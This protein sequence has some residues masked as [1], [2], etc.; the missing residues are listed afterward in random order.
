[1][2][3][4]LIRISA[5]L[6]ASVLALGSFSIWAVNT[7]EFADIGVGKIHEVEIDSNDDLKN[8]LVPVNEYTGNIEENK[9]L[10]SIDSEENFP[11]EYL[12]GTIHIHNA[13]EVSEHLKNLV[14][15]LKIGEN[16]IGSLSLSEGKIDF[17][18]DDLLEENELLINTTGQGSFTRRDTKEI[19][20]IDFLIEIEGFQERVSSEEDLTEPEEEYFEVEITDP[21]EFEQY[22]VNETVTMNYTVENTG[23]TE[24]AQ[25]IELLVD[26]DVKEIE[27]EIN[28]SIGEK[29][30]GQF[31][32]TAE[33]PYGERELQVNSENDQ[34]S[35]KIIV[36]GTQMNINDDE[37]TYV[38]EPN[39]WETHWEIEDVNV[40]GLDDMQLIYHY[41][42]EGEDGIF[43][44]AEAGVRILV[45]GEQVMAERTLGS[46]SE[47]WEDSA[48]V[49]GKD[50]V[51]IQFQYLTEYYEFILLVESEVT[52]SK[53]GYEYVLG[54][55]G[56][57][58]YPSEEISK[59]NLEG[60]IEYLQYD[61]YTS[62]AYEEWY[63]VIDATDQGTELQI[64]LEEPNSELE[65]V[66]VID[67]LVRRTDNS[68]DRIPDV[69]IELIQDEEEIT[70]LSDEEIN[71]PGG[72]VITLEFN[73]EE[74]IDSTGKDI[75]IEIDGSRTGGSQE[76]RN[77]IEIGAVAWNVNAGE[78]GEVI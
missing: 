3:P 13:G 54:E 70:D 77:T 44:S 35:I 30:E 2:K 11:R 36:K 1:M 51:D 22:D 19:F 9:N 31:N 16:V 25:D 14:I 43:L 38:G 12:V 39:E 28:L 45:D 27:E 26:G 21:E 49:S 8:I 59:N 29:Y 58:L 15:E 33:K 23:E 6:I 46:L 60:T 24:D 74:L 68:D 53:A 34:D 5:I 47:E 18:V 71:S 57:Q 65:G 42:L 55:E 75:T 67:F 7:Q 72:E 20:D 62:G 48:D 66:Q 41:E 64:K 78:G 40:D 4:Q 17:M 73:T 61:P 50:S 10:F 76:D 63:E 56:D 69:D 37:E 52:I 32:W